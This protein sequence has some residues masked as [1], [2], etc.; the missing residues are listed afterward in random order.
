MLMI[1]A[2]VF[3]ITLGVEAEHKPLEQV[4]PSLGACSGHD[5]VAL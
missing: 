5:Q 3:E 1:L 4:A 2:G